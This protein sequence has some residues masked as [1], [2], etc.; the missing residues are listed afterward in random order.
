MKT[1]FQFCSKHFNITVPHGY[2]INPGCYGD[3]LA[4]W[5]IR[6][7]NDVGIK[8]SSTPGQED[9]GW[10]FTFV[11][12]EIEHCLI[13][14]FQP[15]DIEVGDCWLGWI[16]RNAGFMGSIL[17][18]RQQGILPEA[19]EVIDNVLKSTKEIHNIQ[20]REPDV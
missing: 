13:V 16:E 5:L 10:Y 18:A 4:E 9:F 2:F 8:T 12:Q 19:I 1:S 11:V 17:G 7:L 20:W 15:N 3:D 6:K 14:G